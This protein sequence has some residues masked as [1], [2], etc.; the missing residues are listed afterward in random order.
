ME[1]LSSK[2]TKLIHPNE[3]VH[4]LW[5]CPLSLRP[6]FRVLNDIVCFSSPSQLSNVQKTTGFLINIRKVLKY[7]LELSAPDAWNFDLI[8]LMPEQSF[9]N[10]WLNTFYIR[11][12]TVKA[13]II[14]SF[15]KWRKSG[16]CV[17][18]L[19]CEHNSPN[20]Q[21]HHGLTTTHENFDNLIKCH[22]CKT[23]V[24]TGWGMSFNKW[25]S[26]PIMRR[27]FY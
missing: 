7:N 19:G 20:F 18:D 6:I 25:V 27:L 16:I 14:F 4:F 23:D 17:A 9:S 13:N 3:V 22:E 15:V 26:I 1:L 12:S 8:Y 24:V 2:H 5:S 10:A 11:K 21:V